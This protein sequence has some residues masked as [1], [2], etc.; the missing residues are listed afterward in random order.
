M[1]HPWFEP[2]TITG[3]F[4]FTRLKDNPRS[5][6]AERRRVPERSAILRDEVIELTGVAAE[7]IDRQYAEYIR[8]LVPNRQAA[9]K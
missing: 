5:R 4:F 9:A 3:V 1:D 8:Q 7:E 6:V 2:L